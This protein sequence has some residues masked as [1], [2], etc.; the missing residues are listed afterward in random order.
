M[1]SEGSPKNALGNMGPKAFNPHTEPH[2]HI[3]NPT[4]TPNSFKATQICT[5]FT[6]CLMLLY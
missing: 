4:V 3:P 5:F 6:T 1:G 2:I